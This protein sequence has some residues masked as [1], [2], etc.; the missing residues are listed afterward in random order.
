MVEA[1]IDSLS[2]GNNLGGNDK[3]LKTIS[4]CDAGERGS[5]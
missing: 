4:V 2:R 1:G 5:V 3:G